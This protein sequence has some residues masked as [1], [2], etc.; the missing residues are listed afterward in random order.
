MTLGF[1]GES[2]VLE[3][4]CVDCGRHYLLVSSFLLRD[5]GAY[6][7]A[8]TAL[9]DHDGREAWI[10]LVVGNWADGYDDHV[11]FGC[12]VGPVAG[13]PDPAATAVDAARPYGDTPL[14]GRKLSRDEALAHPR[15]GEFWDAVD[16]L[17]ENEPTIGHHVYHG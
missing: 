12:R 16:F 8:K 13:S 10:D 2:S 7:V 3:Q 5:G 4:T 15:I 6:A 1:D 9:H 14:W 17:L 11:T